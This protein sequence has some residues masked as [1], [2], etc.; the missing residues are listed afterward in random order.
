MRWLAGVVAIGLHVAPV[1][2][3]AEQI[4]HYRTPDGTLGYSDDPEAVPEDAE[5]LEVTSGPPESVQV[6]PASSAKRSA[7]TTTR[8]KLAASRD[9]DARQETADAESWAN[10]RR[11]LDK[12]VSEAAQKVE[13]DRLHVGQQC[14]RRS[15]ARGRRVQ[16]G[17]RSCTEATQRLAEA[18]RALE[19]A[20]TAAG[21]LEE[22][23]RVAGCL[24]GWIRE[25]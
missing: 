25:D 4:V 22:R 21:E 13:A 3:G 11:R 1:H 18:E 20:R 5:I 24:P 16:D 19:E 14:W 6:H 15:G 10:E 12:A 9:A 23:C 2:V 8:K 17:P 7:A